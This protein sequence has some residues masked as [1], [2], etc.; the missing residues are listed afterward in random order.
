MTLSSYTAVQ[1][2]ADDQKWTDAV[3]D[4][5]VDNLETWIANNVVAL[6]P[7][8]TGIENITGNWTFSGNN[9]HSGT[10]LF[11][12]TNTWS[13]AANFNGAAAFSST[14][15]FTG[16]ITSSGTNTWSGGNTFSGSNTFNSTNTFSG[17]NTFSATNIFSADQRIND[18][19]A[20]VDSSGNEYLQ[21]EET[22][23]AVNEFS[24]TNAAA[25]NA[26]ELAA[27]GGDTNINIKLSPKGTG[28]V[29]SGTATLLR[30]DGINTNIFS[31]GTSISLGTSTDASYVDVDA[32][33]AKITF[34][35]N[36]PG[37]YIVIFCFSC[38]FVAT[39]AGNGTIRIG[40]QLTDGTSTTGTMNYAAISMTREDPYFNL[41]GV[42]NF[43][44]TGSKTI[45]LQKLRTTMTNMSS[46][47]IYTNSGANQAGGLHM[48][49][50]RIA[51]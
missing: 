24:I 6:C 27:T 13:S 42:Y 14:V 16:N 44:S 40:F 33:N 51:D 15:S 12:G 37:R 21:F 7:D 31:N 25:G 39:G 3:M 17:I 4:A 26:P 47:D 9:V 18:G 49:A 20:L 23:S 19:I 48:Y 36:Y 35:V 2:W 38:T 32:T 41:M 34:T 45:K 43:T 8:K 46:C 22:A 28:V 10:Q 29:K 5:F 30:E 50:Y 1:G 11:S